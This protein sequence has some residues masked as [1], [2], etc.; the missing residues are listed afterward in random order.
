[1]ESTCTTVERKRLTMMTSIRMLMFATA[2]LAGWY[3]YNQTPVNP[4]P[5]P[6]PSP[7]PPTP[8]VERLELQ[9][10]SEVES[11]PSR[12]TESLVGALDGLSKI[13]TNPDDALKLARAFKHWGA[14]LAHED[15]LKTLNDFVQLRAESVRSQLGADPL[16]KDYSG[17]IEPILKSAYNLHLKDLVTENGVQTEIT[18]QVRARLVDYTNAVSWKFSMIWLDNIVPINPTEGY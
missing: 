6:N 15:N 12:P 11:F 8:V 4:V 13:V 10:E 1:M 16:S 9:L 14:M 18:P 7:K 17:K 3:Q 5:G 2:I